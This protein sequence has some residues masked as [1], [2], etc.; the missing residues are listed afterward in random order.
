M[1]NHN[2]DSTLSSFVSTQGESLALHDWPLS[3]GWPIRGVVLL[4][5]GLGEHVGR[6]VHV[7][8]QLN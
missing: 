2:T 3:A 1:A 4:V 8:D 7:A 5:H 6:Y